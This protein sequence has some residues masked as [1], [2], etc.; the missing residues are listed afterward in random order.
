MDWIWRQYVAHQYP[1]AEGI[2]VEARNA[3]GYGKTV[4]VAHSRKYRTRYAH[5]DKILVKPGQKVTRSDTI[6]RVGSTGYVRSKKG[7]DASHLHFEVYAFGK[8]VNPMYFFT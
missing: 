1:A 3:T 4:V 2:V 8:K 7:R 5:L 6:G